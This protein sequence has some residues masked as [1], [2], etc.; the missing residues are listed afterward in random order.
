M[1]LSAKEAQE[2]MPRGYI[3][4]EQIFARIKTIA[5]AGL[6]YFYTDLMQGQIQE[7]QELGYKVER[8]NYDRRFKITWS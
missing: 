8:G 4:S 6:D 2:L 7:F 3:P 5:E 1:K